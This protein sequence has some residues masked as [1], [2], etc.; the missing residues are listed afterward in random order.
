MRTLTCLG[1]TY[2]GIEHY[3]IYFIGIPVCSIDGAKFYSCNLLSSGKARS[4][5]LFGCGL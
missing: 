1:G 5:R 3:S 4:F 2:Y